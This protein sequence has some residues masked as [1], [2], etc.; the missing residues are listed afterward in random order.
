MKSTPSAAP[1]RTTN[2]SHNALL[3]LG[4]GHCPGDAEAPSTAERGIVVVRVRAP[5]IDARAVTRP[6]T[7]TEVAVTLKTR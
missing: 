3:A 6:M 5:R 7:P 2:D 1:V 4:F